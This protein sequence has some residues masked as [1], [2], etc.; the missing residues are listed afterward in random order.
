V[1][2]HQTAGLLLAAGEGQLHLAAEILRIVVTEQEEGDGVGVRRH[3]EGFRAADA[4]VRTSRDV[5]H[6]VAARFASRNVHRR[7]ATHQVRR[8]FDV[9]EM[10]L[11]V[12]ARRHVQDLV[13]VFLGQLAQHVHLRG[14]HFPVRDLDAHHARRVPIGDG[15]LRQL[16]LRELELLRLFPVVA[17]PVVVALAVDAA[18]QARLR[19]HLFF[20]FAL[21]TQLHLRLEDV[22]LSGPFL[23]HLTV[24]TFFPGLA[25]RALRHWGQAQYSHFPVRQ[26]GNAP[27]GAGQRTDPCS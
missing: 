3:I 21:L 17:L 22:D 26:L 16:A 5:A 20:E 1:K 4:R 27:A 15:A 10:Q 18:T 9:H 23:A 14:R 24:E 13:R 25:L 6:R 2:V 19:E 8:V 12:L 11:N 7:Q